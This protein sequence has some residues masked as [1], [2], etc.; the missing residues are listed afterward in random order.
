[1]LTRQRLSLIA[2]VLTIIVAILLIVIVIKSFLIPWINKP[3]ESETKIGDTFI[4]KDIDYGLANYHIF[5]ALSQGCIY[6]ESSM[7]L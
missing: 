7:P 5:I 4:I 3:N 1:M 6:C 2:D